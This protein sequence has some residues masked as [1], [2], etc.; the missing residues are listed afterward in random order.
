MAPFRIQVN[1]RLGPLG[2][3][4]N[5][6]HATAPDMGTLA[7]AVVEIMEDPLLSLLSTTA[8]IKSFLLSEDGS[9][10]FFTVDR[11]VPGTNGDTGSL[12]PLWNSCKV[13]FPSADFGR[14][15]LKYLKGVVGE[16]VQTAG[17]L[18]TGFITLVGSTINDMLTA[19]ITNLTPLGSEGGGDYSS[20]SV[21]TE[22]QM[23][24]MHRKRKKKVVAP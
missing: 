6:W 15:D 18:E 8:N 10:A 22:V 13:L 3:W 5:V 7:S 16:N 19:M 21:Q 11:N 9:D 4:S 12:L 24:Q 14:P 20:A 2:K 17:V 23:R 1:Y